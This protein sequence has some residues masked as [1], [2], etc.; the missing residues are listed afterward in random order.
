[1]KN[2]LDKLSFFKGNVEVPKCKEYDHMTIPNEYGH[3]TFQ[4]R[5]S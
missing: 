4:Q 1:M 2:A 3:M 5:L